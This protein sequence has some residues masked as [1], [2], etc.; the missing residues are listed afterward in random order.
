MEVHASANFEHWAEAVFE[1]DNRYDYGERRIRA[2]GRVEG[3]G[4]CIVFTPRA[5][6]VRI[7]T[8]RPMHEKEAR[9]YGI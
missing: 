1:D 5:E 9:R 2:F 4:I 6:A 3:R 7:I 8:V